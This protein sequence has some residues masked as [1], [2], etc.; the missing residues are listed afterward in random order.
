MA[1]ALAGGGVRCPQAN[2]HLSELARRACVA[3][4]SMPLEKG[5][6]ERLRRAA[7]LRRTRRGAPRLDVGAIVL[8]ARGDRRTVDLPRAREVDLVARVAAEAVRA[9]VAGGGRAGA[10][11]ATTTQREPPAGAQGGDGLAGRRQSSRWTETRTPRQSHRD[12]R[13]K[14]SA[15]TRAG[16]TGR[17]VPAVSDRAATRRTRRG[18]AAR[19]PCPPSFSISGRASGARARSTPS[20]RSSRRRTTSRTAAS[21]RA[22][23]RCSSDR[24]RKGPSACAS[25]EREAISAKAKPLPKGALA[26]VKTAC[27]PALRAQLKA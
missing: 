6:H 17:L 25:C 19:R 7:K 23:G 11:A 8:A 16:P 21:T 9:A 22:P 10:P 14:R 24:V 12:R 20:R 4:K 5:A 1:H 3:K 13:T 15:R 27:V 26:R 18:W 2:F